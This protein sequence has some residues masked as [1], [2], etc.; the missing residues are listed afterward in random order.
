MALQ[1]VER[2]HFDGILFWTAIEREQ[3]ILFQI[4]IILIALVKVPSSLKANVEKNYFGRVYSTSKCCTD[5]GL[6]ENIFLKKPMTQVP[7][8]ILATEDH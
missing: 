7:Q 3:D 2:K 5:K 4:V 1:N 8:R 6:R